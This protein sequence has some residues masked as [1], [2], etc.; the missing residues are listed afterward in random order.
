VYFSEQAAAGVAAA[1]CV[2]SMAIVLMFVPQSTKDPSRL[3]SN[4]DTYS[5]TELNNIGAEVL[6]GWDP[7]T[8]Q[9]TFVMLYSSQ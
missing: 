3:S 8:C 4:R 6:V 5:E 1:M 7:V 9:F 2:V